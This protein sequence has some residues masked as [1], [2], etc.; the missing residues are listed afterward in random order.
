MEE[1]GIKN[2]RGHREHREKRE[3]KKLIFTTENT[4]GTE[5]EKNYNRISRMCGIFKYRGSGNG[6]SK[7]KEYY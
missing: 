7:I 6:L 2:H 1:K 4:E 3:I 5:I